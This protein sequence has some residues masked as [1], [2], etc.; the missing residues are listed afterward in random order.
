MQML[1]YPPEKKKKAT[2]HIKT[3]IA[4]NSAAGNIT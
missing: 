3:G 2:L 1:I 4:K